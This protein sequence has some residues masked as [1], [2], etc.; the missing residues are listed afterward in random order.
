MLKSLNTPSSNQ[1]FLDNLRQEVSH[2]MI[3]GLKQY[4]LEGDVKIARHLI[5]KG[6]LTPQEE[7]DVWQ[8]MIQLALDLDEETPQWLLELFIKKRHKE[9]SMRQQIL[10][11]LLTKEEKC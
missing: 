2:I 1:E 4:A 3:Q 7:K 9:H 11:Q 6:F 10:K 5:D 8:K